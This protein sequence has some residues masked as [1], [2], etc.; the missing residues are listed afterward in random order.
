M[1]LKFS[2]PSQPTE[3][4]V[5]NLGNLCQYLSVRV[6]VPFL[7][8][9]GIR[10]EPRYSNFFLN[11][12]NNS[13]LE[14]TGVIEF[15]PPPMFLGQFGELQDAIRRELERV[16]I[17][18]GKFSQALRSSRASNWVIRIPILTNPN[19]RSG[20]PE[21]TMS[22]NA[23]RIVLRDVLGYQKSSGR[24]EIPVSDLLARVSKVTDEQVLAKS[25]CTMRDPK[26]PRQVRV[27]PSPMTAQRIH[28][29]LAELKG[30]AEWANANRHLRIEATIATA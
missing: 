22:T 18:V 30:L 3:L 11:Q 2:I 4:N 27:M 5:H 19:A 17:T 8:A 14:A 12:R 9:R 28:R 29:C 6:V 7:M 13:P 21:V 23:G 16:G 15:Y 10:L 20:P 24:Y 26:N 1:S 25:T